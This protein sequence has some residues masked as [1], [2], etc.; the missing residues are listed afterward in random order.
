MDVSIT[1]FIHLVE[2]K[3]IWQQDLYNKPTTYITGILSE[4]QEVSDEI[5]PDNIVFL[6]DELGDIF[7]DYCNLLLCLQKEWKIRS[8]QD[9]FVRA[10]RKYTERVDSGD[11]DTTKRQQKSILQSEHDALYK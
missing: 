2:K 10:R 3:S 5:R 6:E 1:D 9:V 7:W 11:R 4:I 8:W